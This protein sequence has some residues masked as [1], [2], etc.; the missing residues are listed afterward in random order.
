MKVCSVDIQNFVKRLSEFGVR[1]LNTSEFAMKHANKSAGYLHYLHRDD[2]INVE[3][4]PNA[5]LL[6]KTKKLS[7]ESMYRVNKSLRVQ[8][9]GVGNNRAARMLSMNGI[10]KNVVWC[11]LGPDLL[12]SIFNNNHIIK[13]LYIKIDAL[14]DIQ[15]QIEILS[16]RGFRHLCGYPSRGQRT[17][18]NSLTA[19]RRKA[20]FGVTHG[21]FASM[22][23]KTNK[24]N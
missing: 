1:H 23:T 22:G 10:G 15:K 4:R 24:T 21:S 8:F 14:E 13:C 20:F 11:Y 6:R 3:M 9:D 7:A 18:T 2:P 12:Q 17:R 16:Y 19:L 5:A